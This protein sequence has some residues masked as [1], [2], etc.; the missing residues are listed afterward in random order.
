[1]GLVK[2]QSIVLTVTG[3]TASGN[4]V[5]RAP[6]EDGDA[7]MVVF[8]PM[9]AVGDVV[10]CRIVKVE[11]RCAYGRVEELLQ[12]SP[13]R[14][15][16]NSCTAFG[17]CGGCVWRHVS[18]EAE[19]QYK[20]QHVEDCLSRIGGV[21]DAAALLR[22]IVPCDRLTGY[23]N[24]AQY[25]VSAGE[26]G[27]PRIGFYAPRSHRIVEQRDC[28]LQPPVF[29]EILDAVADWIVRARVPL[30]D[31]ST[32]TGLL[33]HIYIREAEATGE[34]MVCLVCTSG[35]LP[36]PEWLTETLRQL[37]G[38]T[39]VMVNL[40]R[41]DT[42][43][44]LGD[45][46]FVLWGQAYITDVLCGLRVRLSPRSFY[47]VNRRQAERLYALAREA[48]GLT[49]RETVWDLYCGT[50]TIGLSMAREAGEIIGVEVVEAAVADARRNAE[51]NGIRNA[52]FLCADAEEAVRTLTA[53]GTHPDAVIVDPPRKGCG[54]EVLRA[55]AAMRPERV[56]YV[57]CDPATLARDLHALCGRGYTLRCVTPVD[58]FPRTAHVECVALLTRAADGPENGE[59]ES[60]L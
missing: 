34:R 55:V 15:K 45:S 58:M 50:G 12:P 54:E 8:V 49:G 57:S 32:G 3:V 11:K 10:R 42:N 1:M 48:A 19:L 52:R 4:G 31:E 27:T 16:G 23:R 33:R 7:G 60:T 41:R 5:G 56:V 39:S 30:Y 24:K 44:V 47:Q 59:K 37:E 40:N 13:D 36:H 22:P 9:T 20:R 6:A 28:A 29:R 17:R 43:V 46:E 38:V 53:E 14:V 21:T 51:E 2:N 18:Y 25:P 35:R 26:D